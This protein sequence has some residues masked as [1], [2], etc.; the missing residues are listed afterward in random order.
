LRKVSLETRT[1]SKYRR[2]AA[3]IREVGIIEPLVVHPQK[4]GQFTL[5]DG[6]LRLDVLKE[7]GERTVDCLVAFDDEAF[8]YNHKVNR[9]SPIQEHFMVMQAVRNGVSEQAI[10]AALN[11][12]VATIRE[13]KNLLVGVCPEAVKLLRDKDVN[14]GAIRELRKA[15]PMRQIEIAELMLAS[16]NLTVGYAKC[17]IAATPNEQLIESEREKDVDGI[18]PADI[19]RM[20]R[21]MESIG[22]DF[23]QIEE[24]HGKNVLNLVIVVGYLKTLLDNA[25]VV[26]YLAGTYPELLAEFQKTSESRTLSEGVA[27]L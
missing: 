2:I 16:H 4:D 21:E 11:L 9:L 24:S 6:H 3:S 19:A 14:A 1:T 15:K 20:E 8:T 5:L 17:L 22:G 26:K 7:S 18:S 13:K 12:H 23:R 27:E 10:A 25:R